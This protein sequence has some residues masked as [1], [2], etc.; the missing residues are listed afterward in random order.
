MTKSELRRIYPEKRRNLAPAEIKQLSEQIAETFFQ[1]FD[2]S[3]INYLHCFLPIERLNEIDT[4]IIFEKVWR[5][6]PQIETAVPRVN[7][8]KK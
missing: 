5:D 4:R 6:F 7:N 1:N 3:K 2:L 8:E